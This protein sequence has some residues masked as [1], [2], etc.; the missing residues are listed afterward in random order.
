MTQNTWE[1]TYLAPEFQLARGWLGQLDRGRNQVF[2]DERLTDSGYR[3]WLQR[4]GVR[5]VALPD[6]PLH[7]SAR[8]ER[9]LI[10]R[11]PNYLE[12]RWVSEHW[13][14]YEVADPRPLVR[15]MYGEG[16]AKVVSLSTDSFTLR[17]QSPGTFK[18]LVRSSPFWE[19]AHRNDGC[20]GKRG[21]WTIVRTY[22]SGRVPV[23][24]SFSMASAWRSAAGQADTC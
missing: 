7:E 3:R 22:R 19:L 9:R 1:A 20:V 6:V 12:P 10:L 23:E 15:D 21:K 17:V 4:N 13:R 14:V 2:Y 16:A 11:E 5:Y 18:V 8:R 24:M